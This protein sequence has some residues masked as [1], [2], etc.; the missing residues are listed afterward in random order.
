LNRVAIVGSGLAAVSAA[1]ALIERGVKPTL[2]DYGDL[3]DTKTS[4]IVERMSNLHPEQWDRLDVSHV[5]TNKSLHNKSFPK[6]LAF[7]SDYFY[8]ANVH[9]QPI[10]TDGVPPPVSYAKGGFSVGWGASVLPPDERD[11][12]AWP[13]GNQ[14]L[15]AYFK[16]VLSDLPYS[17]SDDGLSKVFPLYST[18]YDPLDL[19]IGNNEILKKMQ[20]T[21][22]ITDSENISFGQS[23]LLVQSNK[24]SSTNGCSYCG[25]CMSGCVYGCIYKSSQDI[26]KLVSANLLEYVPNVLIQSVSEVEKHVEV[27]MCSK[28]SSEIHKQIFDKVLLGAG[29]VNSTRIVL[30]SKKIFDREIRLLSTVSFIAP[31][32]RTKRMKLDWPNINTQPGIFFEYKHDALSDHWIHTQLSTPNELV[33]EK[34][35]IDLSKTNILQWFK[36][37]MTEH[38]V[39]AHGNLHSD[40]A[41]GY[42]LKLMK[43]A[44][45]DGDVLYTRREQ[46]KITSIA[47]QKSVSKL[48]NL[49]RKLGCYVLIP[50]V[51]D[52][53]KSGGYHVGGTM[54]MMKN[55]IK[56]TDTNLFGNPKG[57]Q[58]IHVI[59]SSIFPSLPG[60]TIGLLAMAN[61]ARI[62]SELKLHH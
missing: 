2:L 52:S 25:Y 55:P 54:P 33:L 32:L 39:I 56:E 40:H 44:T 19:T 30:R 22:S 46:R 48:S 23:R 8:G 34:L 12:E 41:N 42:F 1:K 62:A 31:M 28:N 24:T 5:A 18:S 13:I 49:M 51:Q 9:H 60:T 47:I 53:M 6:K 10:I 26:D 37:R 38:L 27:T 7:G 50:F 20:N 16:Q 3:L 21:R 61:A 59:D 58:H 17:A 11:I 35:C 57:W 43:Q 4:E 45:G 29:A 36:K 14:E 15:K